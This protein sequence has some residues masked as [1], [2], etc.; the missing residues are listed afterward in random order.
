MTTYI[1]D[2]TNYRKI[3][4]KNNG[5]IPIDEFGRT[6]EIHHLDN[7]H[8][9]N[10]PDNLVA[11]SI[12]EHFDIHYSQKDYWEAFMIAKRMKLS[13]EK[14]SNI[15]KEIQ[16]KRV[17]EGTH[18]FLGGSIQREYALKRVEDGSHPGK[19]Q[20]TCEHCSKSGSGITNYVRWHGDNC[21]K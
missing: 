6:F 15:S 21:K 1:R 12:Q 8:K 3:Y 16:K 4:E 18:P 10:I 7:N 2:R 17:E 14:V 19:I 5:P 9:N 11:I 13:P 20:W